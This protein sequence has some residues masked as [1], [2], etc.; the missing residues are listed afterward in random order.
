MKKISTLSLLAMTTLSCNPL[1][2]D[3]KSDGGTT[4]TTE[5][6]AGSE[7]SY[8]FEAE[9]IVIALQDRPLQ[10]HIN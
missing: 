4:T 7:T 10:Y 3:S 6:D 5:T 2:L 8:I 1:T 9:D